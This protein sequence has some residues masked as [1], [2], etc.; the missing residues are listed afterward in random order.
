MANLFQFMNH[1]RH[2]SARRTG[3]HPRR[4]AGQHAGQ[5]AER[6]AGQR[7]GQNSEP[8]SVRPRSAALWRCAAVAVAALLLAA[9]PAAGAVI[10]GVEFADE[11]RISNEPTQVLSLHGMGLL[12][13]RVIFRGYVAALYLPD[14]ADGQQ[15]LS[16]LPRRLE[17]SYFWAIDGKDFGEAANQ[18]LARSLTPS[19]LESLAPRVEELHRAYRDV[20]PSDR[21]SLTYVPNIG[22]QVRLNDDLFVTIPGEDFARAYFGIWLGTEPLDAGLRD[23]LLKGIER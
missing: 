22:T 11:I 10:E 2:R 8:R 17:L 23:E 4:N 6:C 13:Y 15:A 19:Q 18:I 5:H 12:R 9:P 14:G 16:D 1:D 21:Y 3:Q 20:R 7:A